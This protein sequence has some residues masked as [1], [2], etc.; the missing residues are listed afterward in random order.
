MSLTIWYISKYSVPRL[1][2][3]P[4]RQYF[5]SKHFSERD[6]DVTLVSSRSSMLDN[7][8]NL[9]FNNHRLYIDGKLKCVLINGPVI[10]LGFNIKRITS[11]IIFEIRLLI[12]AFFSNKKKPDVVIVSSLSILTFLSGYILKKHFK[13][14]LVCEVRDIWPLTLI[15]AKKWGK[16][17]LI[18][19]IMSW[20]EKIGY[21]NA[22]TIIGTMPKLNEHIRAVAP[23]N[24]YKFHYIPMGFEPEVWEKDNND[25]CFS[26][27][28]EI[29]TKGFFKVGY[30]GSMSNL[31]C[32]DEI[33]NAAKILKDKPICF[34]LLGDGEQKEKFISM[35]ESLNLPNLFFL[36]RVPK[37]KVKNFLKQCDL[38]LSPWKN[39]NSLYKF[40]ISPNKW[41]DY[42][43]SGKPIIVSLN[44][45][46]CIINDAKCG[47]FIESGNPE[48]LAFTINNYALMSKHE[49]ESIGNNGRVYLYKNLRYDVL[50]SKYIQ[51]IQKNYS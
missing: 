42:M 14:S 31:D 30:A 24:E 5:F 44:G 45:P 20:I 29:I 35:A 28:E 23:G 34:L 27:P 13:C 15:E 40:G 50:C 48:K 25:Y 37:Y 7:Y 4:S 36:G 16:N 51:V 11:W 26:L 17:N 19:R 46:Q 1:F 33:I 10:N 18:I 6:M 21:N 49:L 32:I 3:F 38:L 47:V 41:I 12:W 22:D 9:R 39:I 2:G 43:L 8:P